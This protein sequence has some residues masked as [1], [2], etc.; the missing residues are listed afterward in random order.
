MPSI[1]NANTGKVVERL[2]DSGAI[3]SPL[4]GGGV[5]QQLDIVHVG[6]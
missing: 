5:R 3:F 4:S 1:V 2:G 6:R